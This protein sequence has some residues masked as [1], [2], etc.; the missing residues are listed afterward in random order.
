MDDMDDDASIQD[1]EEEDEIED[2]LNELPEI[3][4]I[5][6]NFRI[7]DQEIPSEEILTE[8][9][10]INMIQAD[11]EDQEIEENENEDEDEEIPPVLVKKALDGLETFISFFEQQNFN[12]DD[13]NFF[14][15]YLQVVRVKEIDSKKQS[16]L[17]LFFN[18]CGI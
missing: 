5:Q 3:D 13:L 10:I 15:R 14:R 18:N 16:T 8:E 9:Q 2:L 17:D 11:K 1:F 7:F 4:E 6:E 12:M